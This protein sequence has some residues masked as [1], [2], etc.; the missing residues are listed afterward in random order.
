MN[1]EQLEE[2]RVL[3]A[4]WRTSVASCTQQG[5]PCTECANWA[6]ATAARV[7]ALLDEIDRLHVVVRR[8]IS[9]TQDTDGKTLGIDDEIP[10]G[11][12][13]RMLYEF[14]HLAAS[15]DDAEAARPTGATT[16]EGSAEGG[17]SKGFSEVSS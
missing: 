8:V 6:A 10:V 13:L 2:I 15:V 5:S 16:A 17:T 3:H 12:V 1:R 11:E 14:E 7:P 4:S 9:I